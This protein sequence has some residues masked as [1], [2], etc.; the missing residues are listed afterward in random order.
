MREALDALDMRVYWSVDQITQP[1][2]GAE[3]TMEWSRDADYSWH[4][5]GNFQ[6]DE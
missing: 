3:F 1:L 4:A 2:D 5:L 6:G